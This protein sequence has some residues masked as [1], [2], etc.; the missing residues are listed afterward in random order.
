[1]KLDLAT[2]SRLY[3][4]CLGLTNYSHVFSLFGF[5]SEN[6][7]SSYPNPLWWYAVLSFTFVIIPVITA[8]I[9]NYALYVA[10][11]GVSLVRIL[12]ESFT[13]FS[14]ATHVYFMFV[15]L[16]AMATVLSLFL[17]MEKV[18]SKISAEILSLEWSQS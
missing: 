14:W 4:L 8:L 1:V 2:L 15:P 3:I 7:A 11:A 17:A 16:Y 12:V 13:L 10:V 18:A 5:L 9:D 6:N